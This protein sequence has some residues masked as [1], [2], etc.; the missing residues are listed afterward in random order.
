M[1]DSLP[2]VKYFDISPRTWHEYEIDEV[3]LHEYFLSHFRPL[4]ENT[5]SL[6]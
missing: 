4:P 2:S 6:I 3:E 1:F 5:D